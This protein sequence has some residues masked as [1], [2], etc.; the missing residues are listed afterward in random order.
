MMDANK[1]PMERRVINLARKAV[2]FLGR[3]IKIAKTLRKG[4]YGIDHQQL[5]KEGVEFT[6]LN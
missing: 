3:P 1:M 4:D 5:I 6:V 2:D